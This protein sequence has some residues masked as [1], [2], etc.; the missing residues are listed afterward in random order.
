[1]NILLL[2]H[3]FSDKI[4]GGEARICWELPLVLA[5]RGL[6]IF[7][8][9]SYVE[10]GIADK[11]PANLKVYK[12]P[13]CHPSPGLDASNMLR[14]FLYSLPIIFFKKIDIIHLISSNGPCPFSRFKF[15]RPFV[16]SADIF[17][18]YN[19]PK[20]KKELWEDR[21]KKEEAEGINYNPSFFEK[22]FDRMTNW[23]YGAFKLEE[24]YPRGV[25]LFACR[26]SAV[27]DYLG[28]QK[29]KAKLAYVPNGVNTAIFNP[30]VPPIFKKDKFIFLFL[31]K[32][33]KT[34]GTLYLIDA[35]NKLSREYESVDLILV[36]DGAPS[37]VEDI[38][39]KAKDNKRIYFLGKKPVNEIK[40]YYISCDVFVMPSLSEGFGIANLEAMACG[41]P[42]IS[43]KV[44][45]IVDVVVDG[46]TGLLIEPANSN[47]LYLAMKKFL[48]SP[49]LIT[50]MGKEARERAVKNFSWE[51]VAE[52][53]HNAYKLVLSHEKHS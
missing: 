23:F 53:L 5:K 20:I 30:E 40:N 49:E 4:I 37:T 34:K 27:I 36:G 52:K 16:E 9:S 47:E 46:K 41:K 14:M 24:A 7:V 6:N 17:H 1:M 3:T 10:K 19:N 48:E 44:G 43:T 8:V 32:L 35:F 21:L 25:D 42:V 2:T 15:G 26:A 13:F 12:V 33:T 18:D 11:L 45:G 39:D 22:I 28:K 50:E 38:K 29:H 51:V 31:G